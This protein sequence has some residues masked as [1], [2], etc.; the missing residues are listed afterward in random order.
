VNEPTAVVIRYA[1]DVIHPIW[2]ILLSY[3]TEG[4][5]GRSGEAGS[6]AV[7][8]PLNES[9]D[10]RGVLDEA[11]GRMSGGDILLLTFDL[12]ISRRVLTLLARRR[13]RSG[14]YPPARAIFQ[15]LRQAGL[16]I[17]GKYVV[18]PSVSLPRVCFPA[19][20]F[21][22]LHWVQRSGVLGGG[23][24]NL[25]AR[26]LARSALFTPFAFLLAPG[27]AVV[28]RSGSVRAIEP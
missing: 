18:W 15:R 8:L 12:G 21:R 4:T 27:V 3:A 17:E 23:G 2:R 7:W 26:A 10:W 16:K 19:T 28:T 1:E 24:N 13:W 14:H 6:N 9:S 22:P 20:S 11:M 25:I 5:P